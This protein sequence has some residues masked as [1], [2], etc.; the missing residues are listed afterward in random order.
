MANL[1]ITTF[2]TRVLEV[3]KV[4]LESRG[5]PLLQELLIINVCNAAYKYKEMLEAPK[6]EQAQKD[7]LSVASESESE[8]VQEP[9]QESQPQIAP[10]EPVEFLPYDE[11]TDVLYSSPADESTSD[12]DILSPTSMG[13]DYEYNN[14]LYAAID[15]DVGYQNQYTSSNQ[16]DVPEA[17]DC[18]DADYLS[19]SGTHES[20]SEYIDLASLTPTASQFND[21]IYRAH[22]DKEDPIYDTSGTFHNTNDSLK[23]TQNSVTLINS[24]NVPTTNTAIS[25]THMPTLMD[26]VSGNPLPMPK[27]N[28]HLPD[29]TNENKENKPFYSSRLKRKH[30]HSLNGADMPE[31]APKQRKLLGSVSMNDP[32]SIKA[33]KSQGNASIKRTGLGCIDNQSTHRV[34]KQ[35]DAA[36]RS[37]TRTNALQDLENQSVSIAKPTSNTQKQ[38]FHQYTSKTPSK[39]A[40]VVTAAPQPIIQQATDNDFT[41]ASPKYTAASVLGKKRTRH[42]RDEYDFYSDY[43]RPEAK[44]FFNELLSK[45]PF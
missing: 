4:K 12:D 18:D 42:E 36:S 17:L 11:E 26:S 19:S 3:G 35:S 33:S 20:E 1:N 13:N 31:N 2:L 28:T 34:N 45:D 25:S 8:Q 6:E 40:F 30:G 10:E 37:T 22:A 14:A 38:P 24:L 27:S 16:D 32:S 5:L 23:P 41:A 15:D 44:R 29:V 7:L 21:M 9:N 43:H 39:E